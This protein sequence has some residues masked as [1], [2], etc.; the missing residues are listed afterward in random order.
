M[1]TTFKNFRLAQKVHAMEETF[2]NLI[3]YKYIR[4]N[5]LYLASVCLMCTIACLIMI[6]TRRMK[7]NKV[8]NDE[9]DKLDSG[10][11]C[12][13]DTYLSLVLQ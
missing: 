9:D 2:N 4:K 1:E 12:Q 11:S 10:L 7:T 6:P 13:L 5:C 3:L 8:D